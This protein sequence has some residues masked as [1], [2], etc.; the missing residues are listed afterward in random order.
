MRDKSS[1]LEEKP[2][3]TSPGETASGDISPA[4]SSSDNWIQGARYESEISISGRYI[5][6]KPSASYSQ[7]PRIAKQPGKNAHRSDWTADIS[8][9]GEILVLAASMRGAD[10]Y[11]FSTIRQDSFA[12]GC[13]GEAGDWVI[14]VIADGVA[15]AAQSH[16]F[17]DYMARQAVLVIGRELSSSPIGA[18]RDVKWND[19]AKHLVDVS[20]EFCRIAAKRVLPEDKKSMV[21]EA[22]PRNFVSEFATTL[23]FAVVRAKN[24][25]PAA[26]REFVH[27]AVA[28][29]GA[30]YV[31]NKKLGWK[32][33][34]IGK[35]QS[36]AVAS[37]AVLALP[38]IPGE[39]IISFGQ[40]Q[41]ED[42]LILTTD[43][44]GDFISDG[45]TELGGFFQDR[46]PNCES[47]PA[48]LQV[49]DVSLYQ[50]ADDRTLIM[51]KGTD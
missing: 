6:G 37:N 9:L 23:E 8:N 15:S 16:T 11:G 34:K 4:E 50:A 38:L 24:D 32:T 1:K 7:V 14:A 20:D 27:V 18:L 17:A 48:F 10:H 47:L 13:E 19:V 35:R 25:D 2:D 46:L 28:G 51:I 12:I 39:F 49:A 40:L 31:L 42:C 26:E 44:L 3:E 22:I 29:D 33:V 30:A 21:D 5:L 36:G 41:K 45:N 43:G